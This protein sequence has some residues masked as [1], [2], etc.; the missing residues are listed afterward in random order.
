LNYP[1]PIV[2]KKRFDH[3]FRFQGAP[4]GILAGPQGTIL[5]IIDTDIGKKGFKQEGLSST[6][7]DNRIDPFVIL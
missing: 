7:K 3:F 1:G 6:G 4:S 2:F 5:A